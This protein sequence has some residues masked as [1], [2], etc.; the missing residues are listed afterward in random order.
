[1]ARIENRGYFL[2]LVNRYKSRIVY[3]ASTDLMTDEEFLELWNHA[4][5]TLLRELRESKDGSCTYEI[6]TNRIGR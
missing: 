3:Q 2:S 5:K 1:M 4:G 6:T